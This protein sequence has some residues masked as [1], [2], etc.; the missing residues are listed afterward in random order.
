[1]STKNATPALGLMAE[2]GDADALIAAAQRATD[3]G[4]EQLSAYA[5]HEVD[6]LGDALRAPRSR[7]GI[8]ML[9]GA[10][11]GGLGT[12]AVEWYSSVIAYPLDIGGRPA[13]SWPLFVP[14]AVEMCLLGAVLAGVGT[15]LY[16]CRLPVL[17][18]VVFDVDAFGRASDD[19]Y[20]LALWTQQAHLDEDDARRWLEAQQPIAV[21]EVRR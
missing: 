13:A 7:I 1:M 11:L 3:D 2:F 5:P 9:C 18:H 15:F 16:G 8:A 19:R 12:Y 6:G 10:L 20:F 4:Y 17:H 21:H 14:P